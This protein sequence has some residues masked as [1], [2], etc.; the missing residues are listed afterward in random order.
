M[1][2]LTLSVIALTWNCPESIQ[3]SAGIP[4]IPFYDGNTFNRWT[5]YISESM[6][7]LQH[8][9][10]QECCIT[11]LANVLIYIPRQ[12][13]RQV[14]G[15]YMSDL[16]VSRLKLHGSSSKIFL[17]VK[18]FSFSLQTFTPFSRC[19]FALVNILWGQ[20]TVV[21]MEHTEHGAYLRDWGEA[22]GRSS[23]MEN[24][25]RLKKCHYLRQWRSSL[26]GVRVWGVGV[27]VSD[28]GSALGVSRVV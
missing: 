25:M 22:D 15:T 23:V 13:T 16:R 28:T 2:K 17:C 7:P 3:Y 4:L 26:L 1:I 18:L 6:P 10:C 19:S 27:W 11:D 8:F 14:H 24:V 20:W 21:W 5:K 9:I 12:D